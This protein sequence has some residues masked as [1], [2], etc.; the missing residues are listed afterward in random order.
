MS[1]D[2]WYFRYLC[3]SNFEY[4]YDYKLTIDEVIELI[5]KDEF[6]VPEK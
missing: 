6:I 5:N 1:S 2:E 3:Y 4:R